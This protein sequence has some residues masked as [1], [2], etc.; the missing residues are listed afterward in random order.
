VLAAVEALGVVRPGV[1]KLLIWDNAP[2]HMP[3]RVRAAAHQAGIGIAFLPFRAPELMPLEEL[4][5]GRKATVAAN[6]C[7]DSL[8][9]LAE[10]AVAWWDGMS[11]AERRRRCGLTS[12]KFTWLPT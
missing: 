6:R 7:D 3:L 10:R 11:D 5:R 2:P 4:W 1:P 9:E 12:A 8:E